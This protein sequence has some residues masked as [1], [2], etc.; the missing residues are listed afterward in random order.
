MHYPYKDAINSFDRT[1]PILLMIG[2][3]IGR[4]QLYNYKSYQ[5]S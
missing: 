3:D 5:Y 4:Y 1:S 2:R